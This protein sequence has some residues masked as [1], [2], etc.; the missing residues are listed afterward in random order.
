MYDIQNSL[1]QTENHIILLQHIDTHKADTTPL[2][3]RK[4]FNQCHYNTILNSNTLDTTTGVAI[5]YNTNFFKHCTI[6]ES[7]ES[8]RI[9]AVKLHH[10]NASKNIIIINVYGPPTSDPT[11]KSN[12]FNFLDSTYKKALNNNDDSS[13]PILIRGDF[14]AIYYQTDTTSTTKRPEKS[15][16]DFIDNNHLIDTFWK[17]RVY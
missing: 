5:L 2:K 8:Y 10:R 1:D 14:N 4:C 6:I 7:H 16:V 3:I 13:T 12:F 9:L 11:E 17:E 15:F